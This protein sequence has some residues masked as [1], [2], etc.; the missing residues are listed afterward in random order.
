M[1]IFRTEQRPF[2]EPEAGVTLDFL[3]AFCAKNQI[4]AN[5]N[6]DCDHGEWMFWWREQMTPEEEQ[7]EWERRAEEQRQIDLAEAEDR[8]AGF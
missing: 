8:K 4:P 5:A 3:V 2:E 6:I 7:A 1:A